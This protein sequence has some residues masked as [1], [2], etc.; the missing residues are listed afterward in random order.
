MG[1]LHFPLVFFYR[2]V[3][4]VVN[5]VCCYLIKKT[6]TEPVAGSHQDYFPASSEGVSDPAES[7]RLW[8]KKGPSGLLSCQEPLALTSRLLSCLRSLICTMGTMVVV[9]SGGM[10]LYQHTKGAPSR[11]QQVL[12]LPPS[13]WG[14]RASKDQPHPWM[15]QGHPNE[16]GLSMDE[17]SQPGPRPSPAPTP[18]I[19]RA[20]PSVSPPRKCPIITN[21]CSSVP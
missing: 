11:R 17:P 14:P 3:I 4:A 19:P 9:R 12:L 21:L 13:P 8:N 7:P 20:A 1:S 10:L 15:N 2:P 6:N 18:S 16:P 5:K